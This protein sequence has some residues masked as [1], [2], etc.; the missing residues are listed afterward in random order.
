PGDPHPP[1]ERVD[2]RPGRD[3]PDHRPP[4]PRRQASIG[5]LPDQHVTEQGNRLRPFPPRF[6]LLFCLAHRLRP[7]SDSRTCDHPRLPAPPPP[8]RRPGRVGWCCPAITPGAGPAACRCSPP[9]RPPTPAPRP[10]AATGK[11][12]RQPP[13]PPPPPHRRPATRPARASPDRRPRRPAA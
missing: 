8:P 4:L 2:M 12:P 1:P 9:T 11:R 10:G 13:R 5:C 3:L 6:L 7:P